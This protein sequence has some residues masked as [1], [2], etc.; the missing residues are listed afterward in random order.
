MSLRWTGTRRQFHG[1]ARGRCSRSARAPRI[2]RPPRPRRAPIDRAARDAA[3]A[4][5]TRKW[6]RPESSVAHRLPGI[7]ARI[8]GPQP[9]PVLG[10][11]HDALTVAPSPARRILLHRHDVMAALLQDALRVG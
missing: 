10:I 11:N 1:R 3:A 4:S 8:A 5:R 2:F 9:L 7:V 6:T